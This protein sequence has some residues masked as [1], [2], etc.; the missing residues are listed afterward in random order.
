MTTHMTSVAVKVHL[1]WGR[2]FHV[3]SHH[4]FSCCEVVR[5]VEVMKAKVEAWKALLML[6]QRSTSSYGPEEDSP[7]VAVASLKSRAASEK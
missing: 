7:A 2:L 6:I 1:D 5:K 3:A 4:P